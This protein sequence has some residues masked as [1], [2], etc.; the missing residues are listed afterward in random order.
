[1]RL[2]LGVDLDEPQHARVVN[3]APGLMSIQ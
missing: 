3:R 2:R 1:M